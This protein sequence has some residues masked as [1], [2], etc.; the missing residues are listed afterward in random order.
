MSRI[1]DPRERER[2]HADNG[3]VD[4]YAEALKASERFRKEYA[5]GSTW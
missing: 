2:A 5:G 1:I 3:H 4:F